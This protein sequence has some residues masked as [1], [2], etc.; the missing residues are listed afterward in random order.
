MPVT[1]SLPP[2]MLAF[3]V[4]LE[5][6]NR[7]E[8]FQS[9]KSRYEETVKDPALKSI[10]EAIVAD[11]AGWRKASAGKAFTKVWRIDGDTLK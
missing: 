1:N 3:L 2:E 10:R 9:R 6:N 11:P 8:W 7:R 5:R 4:D